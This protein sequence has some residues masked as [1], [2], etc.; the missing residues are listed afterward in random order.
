VAPVFQN[1]WHRFLSAAQDIP[2]TYPITVTSSPHLPPSL[3]HDSKH[4]RER[5]EGWFLGDLRIPPRHSRLGTRFR[6]ANPVGPDS[7]QLGLRQHSHH[8]R[9]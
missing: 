8:V 3:T 6:F 7:P 9:R 1:R 2:V 4:E 5:Q